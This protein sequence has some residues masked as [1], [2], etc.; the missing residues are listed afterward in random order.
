MVRVRVRQRVGKDLDHRVDLWIESRHAF[1]CLFSQLPRRDPARA[2]FGGQRG[3]VVACPFIQDIVV[4]A[5]P[6]TL[7]YTHT[8]CCRP[9][10]AIMAGG[11]TSTEIVALQ[12][13]NGSDV[14]RC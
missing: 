5:A 8:T 12:N 13:L 14:T 1:G 9:V 4:M 6:L 3:R 7:G 2:Y 11:V 10:E